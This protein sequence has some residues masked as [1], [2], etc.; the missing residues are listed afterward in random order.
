MATKI[1]DI[2]QEAQ[3]E[4]KSQGEPGIQPAD[5]TGWVCKAITEAFQIDACLRIQSLRTAT[6]P[7][8][9]ISPCPFVIDPDYSDPTQYEIPGT[10]EPFVDGL[11]WYVVFRYHATT[12]DNTKQRDEAYA[13]F[14]RIMGVPAA[15]SKG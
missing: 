1:Q 11:K 10:L 12:P 2:V 8:D 9:V 14:L 15:Q 5:W 6:A 4:T 3:K 7:N 13:I